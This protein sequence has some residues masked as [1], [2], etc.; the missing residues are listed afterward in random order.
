[1]TLLQ[2]AMAVVLVATSSTSAAAQQR[3]SLATD[4]TRTDSAR[5]DTSRIQILAPTVV[6]GTRLSP[7]DE[8]TPVQVDDVRLDNVPPGPTAAADALTRLPGVS[9]FDDQGSRV[10]PTLEIRGFRLSPVVGVPQGVSVFLDGVRIN[11]P[12]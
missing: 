12:D 6:T 4:T 8:K 7:V 2:I 10:Q 11:E 3:D 1:T 5:V 9:M